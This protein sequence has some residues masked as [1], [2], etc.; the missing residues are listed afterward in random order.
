MAMGHGEISLD[1]ES[2][3][4]ACDQVEAQLAIHLPLALVM[5]G[6]LVAESARTTHG[7]QDRTGNLTRSIYAEPV[8]GSYAGRDLSVAVGANANYGAAI[9]LG[10]KPHIIRARK[11]LLR[12]GTVSGLVFTKA[13][14]H[15]GNK[16]YRFLHEALDREAD[17][18]TLIIGNGMTDAWEAA[19]FEVSGEA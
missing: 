10:A 12:F 2:V 7:Y 9:E 15:P 17:D 14:N 3:I 6:D 8:S 4:T 1:V 13:V 5:A 18:L 19:G 11:G 16:P